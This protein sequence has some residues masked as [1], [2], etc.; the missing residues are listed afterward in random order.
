M[1]KTKLRGLAYVGSIAQQS[2]HSLPDVGDNHALRERSAF[3]NLVAKV[4]LRG[5]CAQCDI[6]SPEL[7]YEEEKGSVIHLADVNFAIL[8]EFDCLFTAFRIVYLLGS[9]QL[10]SI[11][12]NAINPFPKPYE[13][14]Q[15]L[16]PA[17]RPD[18]S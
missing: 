18:S 15:L 14:L 12:R 9:S 7:G 8:L 1:V 6:L 13:I 11:P 17:S 4:L 3:E 10:P 2:G 5:A 16:S